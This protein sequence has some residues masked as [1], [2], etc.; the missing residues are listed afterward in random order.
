MGTFSTS[1]VHRNPCTEACFKLGVYIY[2]C[3]E[4]LLYL[5]VCVD[6]RMFTDAALHNATVAI[7]KLPSKRSGRHREV[8]SM[9]SL[10]VWILTI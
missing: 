4:M 5:F 10:V 7:R 8:W 2:I 3:I 9:S 6:L 1:Q